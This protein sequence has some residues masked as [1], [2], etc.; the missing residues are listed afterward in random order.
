M[1]SAG[2]NRVIESGIR[3]LCTPTRGFGIGMGGRNEGNAVA[4]DESGWYIIRVG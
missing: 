1:A 3:P 4:T 2:R